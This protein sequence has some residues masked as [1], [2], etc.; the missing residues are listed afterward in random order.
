MSLAK[1][2]ELV[3]KKEEEIAK[4]LGLLSEKSEGFEEPKLILI[5][6]Y[7]LRVFVP[8]VRSTRDCD[9][10][11]RKDDVWHLDEIKKWFAKEVLVD[12]LEKKDV[13]GYMRCVELIKVNDRQAKVS[14]DFMEGEVTGRSERDRVKIDERFVADSK[15]TKIIVAD[16]ELEVRVPSYRDYF[17]LKIVSAR[18]S[19]VRDVAT[20]V[21]KNGV[22]EGLEERIKEVMPHPEVFKEKLAESILPIMRDKRFLNSW[23]GMFMTDEFDEETKKRV[24]EQ[25]SRRII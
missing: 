19:D 10:A 23:K 9:F 1:Y 12:S 22:P 14:L 2:A 17:L 21:W 5:G 4:L 13:S 6:G 20:L 11:L 18:P 16:K 7:G 25:L 24:I 3:R 8:F 15:K